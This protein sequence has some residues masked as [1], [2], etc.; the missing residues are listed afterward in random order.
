M[1]T[2]VATRVPARYVEAAVGRRISPRWAL[3]Q[4]FCRA[5]KMSRLINTSG[6]RSRF[7]PRFPVSLLPPPSRPL[8]HSPSR[9]FRPAG[10][11]RRGTVRSF[12]DCTASLTSSAFLSSL[13]WRAIK[14]RRRHGIR[15]KRCEKVKTVRNDAQK[16]T[17]KQSI[18]FFV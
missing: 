10:E 11:T 17:L 2:T 1:N 16:I 8:P 7:H 15:I 9:P 6:S 5:M 3:N 4:R 13:Y 14:S 18:F 12:V